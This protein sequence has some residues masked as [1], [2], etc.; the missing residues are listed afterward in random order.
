MKQILLLFIF[1]IEEIKRLKSEIR[2]QQENG[3]DI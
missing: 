3:G 2:V 1:L